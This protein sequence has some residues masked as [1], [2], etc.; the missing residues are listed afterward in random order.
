M[1]ADG[2]TLLVLLV[3]DPEHEAGKKRLQPLMEKQKHQAG[4]RL[5]K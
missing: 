5:L 2:Q 3:G 1:G 4:D